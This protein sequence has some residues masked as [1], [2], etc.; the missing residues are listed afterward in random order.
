MKKKVFISSTYKDLLEHRKEV[1]KVLE[2]HNVIVSG[3]EEFGARKSDSLTTCLEEVRNSDIYIGILG[4]IYGSIEKKSGKSF[5]QLEYEEAI[6]NNLDIYI[7]LIDKNESLL[8][9][10]NID[11][12]NYDKLDEFKSALKSKHTIDW[13]KDSIELK[14]KVNSLLNKLSGTLIVIRP[15]A[16]DT[17]L[18][19]FT[20]NDREYC[21]FIGYLKHKA[22]ETWIGITGDFFVPEYVDKGVVEELKSESRTQYNFIFQDKQGY[23]INMP[24]LNRVSDEELVTLSNTITVFLQQSATTDI[25]VDFIKNK[26]YYSSIRDETKEQIT[27]LLRN[28][29]LQE[30]SI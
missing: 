14:E 16:L 15:K 1:W 23:E 19:R 20:E 18:F 4:M 9:I 25:I 26:T 13:F 24:A 28:N 17:R 7:Y 22:Y 12:R 10:S 5:T 2:K 11:F 27:Q 21:F 29:Y 3:M 8:K 30:V 6:R